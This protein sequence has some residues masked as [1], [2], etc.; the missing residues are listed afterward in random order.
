MAEGIFAWPAS[1][2]SGM[3][4]SQG[5]QSFVAIDGCAVS[6]AKKT[7]EHAGLD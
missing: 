2:Q 5:R 6:C 4:E 1:G 3:I 7:L